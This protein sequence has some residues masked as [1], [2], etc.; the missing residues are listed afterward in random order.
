M[1]PLGLIVVG[2]DV[3]TA[4]GVVETFDSMGEGAAF[5]SM[6]GSRGRRADDELEVLAEWLGVAA[7]KS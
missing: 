7:A 5:N 2:A 1:M 3:M 4:M 6:D